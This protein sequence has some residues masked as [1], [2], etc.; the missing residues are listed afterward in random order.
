MERW[1]W[2]MDDLRNGGGLG[3]EGGREGD[4]W[5]G[6]G[7]YSILTDQSG[8]GGGGGICILSTPEP[9]LAAEATL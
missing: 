7:C 6:C 5:N 4:G 8:G 9:C 2:R 1:K 3:R